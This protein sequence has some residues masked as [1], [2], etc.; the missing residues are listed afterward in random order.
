MESFIVS[1]NFVVVENGNVRSDLSSFDLEQIN[2]ITLPINEVENTLRQI[3]TNPSAGDS[4]FDELN[5]AFIN[6]TTVISV[7]KNVNWDTPVQVLYVQSGDNLIANTRLIIESESSASAHIIS[8]FVS[9]NANNCFTNHVTQISV[10]D[11]AQITFDKLQIE[12]GFNV[13]TEYVTQQANSTFKINTVTLNG[14]LVRNNL[15]IEVEG[16]NCETYLN[17][18]VIAKDKQVV[19]NHTFVN[20]LVPHCMSDEKYKYVLDDKSIGTFNGRVVVHQD[21]QKINAFQDK[22]NILL[23]DYAKINAKPELEIYADDVKCSHGSTTGQLD[24]KAL[25]YLQ[26]R[27]ISKPKARHLLVQAF[28]GDVLTQIENDKLNTLIYSVLKERFG[29]EF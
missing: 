10:A 19:D 20:Q 9:I 7:P 5:T 8:T 29:W 23:S 2:I 21:A 28:V 24:E 18:A 27:G 16:Q 22:G 12:N 6:K 13:S 15:N 14:E 11:N 26:A 25:F 4:I 3:K 1:D 17:G